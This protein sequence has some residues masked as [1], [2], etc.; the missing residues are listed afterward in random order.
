M[1]LITGHTNTDMDSLAA[2][3][4]ARK[5]YPGA[6]M[7]FPGTLN[8]NVRDFVSLHKDALPI[9][10]V[11]EINL[12][13]VK[14]LIIVDTHSPGRIGPLQD[15]LKRPDIE[16]II[17]DHHPQQPGGIYGN[18]EFLAAVGATTTIILELLQEKGIALSPF[19]A[20]VAALG[21]YE[22]TGRFTFT[23][24]TLRDAQMLP[25]LLSA[26]AQLQVVGEFIGWTLNEI[27]RSLLADMLTNAQVINVQGMRIIVAKAARSEFIDDVALI[28]HRMGE[29]Y[30]VDAAL[31]VVLLGNHVYFVGRSY[32]GEINV[33]QIATALGGGGHA[34]AASSVIKNGDIEAVYQTILT[35][36]NKEHCFQR[37]AKDIMSSPVKTI[38]PTVTVREAGKLLNRCGHSGLPVME[39]NKIVGIISRR[40]IEKA[41]HRNYGHA[42]V[43]GFMNAN[44]KYVS[45][46]TSIRDLQRLMIEYDIGR[47]PVL[48]G[49]D[50]IG[51]VSRSDVL[52]VLHGTELKDGYRTMYRITDQFI[53]PA[54]D[55]VIDLLQDQAE[56]YTLLAEAGHA[57]AQMQMRAAVVGGF[58]RDLLLG[59]K[60]EDLD[61]VVE[62]EGL[63]LAQH[64]AQHWQADIRIHEVF[65]TAVLSLPCGR[66]VDIATARTEY[67]EFPAA[68]PTV[69]FSS[70]RQDL[71]RR[72]F[73]I[74]AMAI[75]ISPAGFGNLLD[76]FG[77][78]ADLK[79]G[80]VRIL[81][82]H[83]F[84]DDPTRMFRAIRFEQRY[85][86]VLENQ[87]EQ[88]MKNSITAGVWRQLSPE[89][90]ARELVLIFKENRCRR[91]LKRL[92][93]IRLWPALFCDVQMDGEMWEWLRRSQQ[94]RF[95]VERYTKIELPWL[96][97]PMLLFHRLD[98]ERSRQYIESL[99]FTGRQRENIEETLLGQQ[100]IVEQLRKRD[101]TAWEIYQLLSPLSAEAI[102]F[103]ATILCHH[104]SAT[105]HILRYLRELQGIKPL[106][107]G[108][109]IR[110]LGIKQ[111]PII[112]DILRAIRREKLNGGLRTRQEELQFAML[113]ITQGEELQSGV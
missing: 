62:G 92:D 89:R 34:R 25:L 20:T 40:D 10:R 45:A 76:Y 19:E 70:L 60:S 113:L 48:D 58:V 5:L 23:N 80:L 102:L 42:P 63:A 90:I 111:G 18:Q 65:G 96:V 47:L 54:P 33:G 67:Y 85:G 79:L 30:D 103:F 94:V 11:S 38:G 22:D 83:S 107:G 53:L 55:I 44:V 12:T 56:L 66:K 100:M 4:L 77:G 112:G 8:K 59:L 32:I 24:T 93:S 64:L 104:K 57:A 13:E 15:L 110:Q 88:L 9:L 87:T 69:Q 21:V 75:D 72:D 78:Y 101:L 109:D 16:I 46:D 74:N 82:S 97:I 6:V 35:M 1:D 41:F 36:L 105:R 51:I 26:G 31:A 17:Y 71:D 98:Q 84:I 43:K 73:T 39:N 3:F 37:V 52:R 49:A 2:T 91:I 86:F 95:I 29:L 108:E 28:T 61:I 27:Q 7:V 106:L 81:Y 14:R 68:L 50:L 99:K